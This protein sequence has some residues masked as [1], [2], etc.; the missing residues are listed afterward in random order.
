[1]NPEE[2]KEFTRDWAQ[3]FREGK[4]TESDLY[5]LAKEVWA[6]QNNQNPRVKPPNVDGRY[7]DSTAEVPLRW[8]EGSI[9]LTFYLATEAPKN[10]PYDT[11]EITVDQGKHKGEVFQLLKD[12]GGK[13]IAR[14]AK[15]HPQ[16]SNILGEFLEKDYIDVPLTPSRITRI[17]QILLSAHVRTMME[18]Q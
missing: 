10:E 5:D 7:W 8:G 9:F 1:M 2:P 4:L 3:L 14:W 17:A 11:I 15:S 12:D 6:I 16:Y 13:I 18:T